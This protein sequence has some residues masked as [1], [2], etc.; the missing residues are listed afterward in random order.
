[1]DTIPLPVQRGVISLLEERTCKNVSMHSFSSISG[2]CINRGGKF[3]TSAGDFFVKWNDAKRFP[4]MFEMEAKGLELLKSCGPIEIPRVIGHWESDIYQFIIVELI[5]GSQ[6][7]E[8]FWIDLGHGLAQLHKTTHP[9]FGLDQPN[10]IGS[11]R[12]LNPHTTSWIDFF[13]EQRL[14]IQLKLAVDSSLLDSRVVQKFETLYKQLPSLLTEEMP[15]LLHGD[16]WNGNLL[17]NR[18]KPCL[19]DPAVYYGHREIDLAMCQLFGGFP[20]DFYE[21]Y[22]EAFPLQPDYQKRLHIYNLYP[23]LV[24]VNLFGS[25]YRSQVVSVLNKFV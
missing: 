4:G 15:S 18:G 9:Y 10:Y 13:I 3:Q 17:V 23:L 16:L 24:H 19:I 6:R 7:S 5:E 12:Q 22:I 14:Q 20:D 2:G 21:S 11:L 1:M 25:G 8:T